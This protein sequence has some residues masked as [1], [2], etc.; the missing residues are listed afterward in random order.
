MISYNRRLYCNEQK[1]PYDD[2]PEWTEAESADEKPQYYL[3]YMYNGGKCA[4]MTITQKMLHASGTDES[5]CDGIASIPR[6]IEGV[7]V[8]VTLRERTDGT[9]KVSLRSHAPVDC[10]KICGEMGGGG[11]AR[12]A[13]CEFSRENLE[14]EKAQLLAI[15]TRE[16]DSI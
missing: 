15:I 5:D 3:M 12:A 4:V 14:K 8:G 6:K 16:L 7:L 2:D 10:T 13:G 1:E 11:H 9:Y